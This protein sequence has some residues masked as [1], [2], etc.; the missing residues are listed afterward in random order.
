[1]AFKTSFAE[2]LLSF[3]RRTAP[4]AALQNQ[5]CQQAYDAHSTA[6]VVQEQ[7]SV[8]INPLQLSNGACHV[9]S[10]LPSSLNGASQIAS[11]ASSLPSLSHPSSFNSL[12]SALQ[13]SGQS[14]ISQ[15]SP[16]TGIL[17]S[18]LQQ[19]SQTNPVSFQNALPSISGSLQSS[20]GLMNLSSPV[21]QSSLAATA[22]L[23][24]QNPLQSSQVGQ[25]D[26]QN[27]VQHLLQ[28]MMMS[29]Q[30][31]EREAFQQGLGGSNMWGGIGGSN[32]A[33]PAGY[34]GLNGVIAGGSLSNGSG[35]LGASNGVVGNQWLPRN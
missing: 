16:T 10:S 7:G 28:E 29:Q 25:Q 4:S 15:Q 34:S 23:L 32:T 13:T 5:A 21:Q 18:A 6:S 19:V 12:Q 8:I 27:V 1:M 3:P 14:S 17:S 11:P 26:T 24:Q 35:A 9:S 30:M 31:N 33:G 22:S 2:S 20:Q